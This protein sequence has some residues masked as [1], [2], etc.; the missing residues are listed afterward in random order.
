[1]A[2]NDSDNN[3]SRISI[4]NIDGRINDLINIRKRIMKIIEIGKLSKKINLA[5]FYASN[6]DKTMIE[7]KLKKM[8]EGI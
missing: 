4:K 5:T 2:S 7:N 1:M 6:K 8:K 3:N